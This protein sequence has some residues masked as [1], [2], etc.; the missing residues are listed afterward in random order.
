[1]VAFILSNENGNLKCNFKLFC[2]PE[3]EGL[4]THRL[5]PVVANG[6]SRDLPTL[7]E[8]MIIQSDLRGF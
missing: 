5:R 8:G 4:A 2:D 6:G 1:M 3:W 7:G